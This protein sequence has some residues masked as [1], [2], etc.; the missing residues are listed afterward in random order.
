MLL[1]CC[2]CSIMTSEEQ[3]RRLPINSNSAAAT[4]AER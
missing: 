3:R 1:T 2:A 4:H